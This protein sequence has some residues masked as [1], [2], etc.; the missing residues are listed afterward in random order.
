M[1]VVEVKDKYSIKEF[2]QFPVRLYKNEKTWIRPLD[3]D[4]ENVFDPKKN[5]TFR[6]GKCI[7]WILQRDGKT[8]GRIA[9]FVN[10]K[11]VHKDNDQP[12]GGLGFF[13]CI[14]DQGVANLLF[15]TGKKWLKEQGMEAM[16]GPINFGE[17]DKWWG[18]LIDG[19]HIEPNY[20]CNYN[21][22]YYVQLFEN[23]GFQIY[24]KQLTF[25]RKVRDPFS[26]RLMEKGER[27]MADKESGYH[28]EH[29]R[30]KNLAKY[31]EDF[32]VVYNKA[33][34]RHKGVSKMTS[35]QAKAIM[36]Q[37]KPIIDEK[38]I[39]FGYHNNEPVAFYI[40]LPEVNQIFKYVNGK[41]DWIGKLKFVYHKWR[42]SCNKMLGLVFGI[43]PEH[44]GKGVE[45]ALVLATAQMVQK[46]YQRYDDLEMNWIGDFNPKM[47]R[48]VEQ[49]GG[50]VVK[51]HV[52]YRKLFDETKP[53]KRCP[54][55]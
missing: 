49:V 21:F 42:K 37:M 26:K 41:L 18:C 53:F 15:D 34:A 31:T 23:Y 11:T 5:K 46:D 52:T 38:I 43:A 13:E 9:A 32:R 30:L 55:Q 7:R 20:N 50:D 3:K 51:T 48:V 6:N 47:I 45:G 4:I 29:L 16:D 54:I 25:G 39:W 33:W 8:I 22:P 35:L 44:Q 36:K 24:F 2:I 27:I 28:F 12:T 14:N 1:N 40:N 19:F 17:R 10:E